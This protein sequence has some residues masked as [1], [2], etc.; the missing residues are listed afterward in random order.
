MSDKDRIHIKAIIIGIVFDV[1]GTFIFALIFAIIAAF[2]LVSRG[3]APEKIEEHLAG[4][5][6]FLILNLFNGLF[7]TSLG[8]YITALIASER[9]LRHALAMG[10]ASAII[11]VVFIII[12]PGS[13]LS[14]YDLL[15][16]LFI[17]PCALLGGHMRIRHLKRTRRVY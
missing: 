3:I 15:S 16:L 2:P 7:F 4:S 17:I 12:I 6:V 14:W 11:G 9:E 10:I 1:V 5:P 13:T 8:G